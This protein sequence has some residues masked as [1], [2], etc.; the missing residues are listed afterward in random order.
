VKKTRFV[1]KEISPI[2]FF[3]GLFALKNL[4]KYYAHFKDDYAD[5]ESAIRSLKS[6]LDRINGDVKKL[7]NDQK[8]SEI[9]NSFLGSSQVRGEEEE[10]DHNLLKKKNRMQT[11]L[12]PGR[13]F[14]REGQLKKHR[15]D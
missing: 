15:S 3:F 14:L 9:Q 12:V 8:L 6:V 10:C 13:T 1:E 4:L 5:L 11:I 7:Q 2:P